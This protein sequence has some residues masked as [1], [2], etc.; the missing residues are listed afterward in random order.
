VLCAASIAASA[1][2]AAGAMVQPVRQHLR[3]A[4]HL[5]L[6]D[7]ASLFYQCDSVLADAALNRPDRSPK[8]RCEEA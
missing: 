6:G 2:S 3:P 1:R 4:L 7:R 5:R 8:L